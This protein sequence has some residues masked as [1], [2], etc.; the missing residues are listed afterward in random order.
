VVTSVD[1][2]TLGAVGGGENAFLVVESFPVG[3]QWIVPND[4][5]TH[6]FQYPNGIVYPAGFTFNFPNV[7]YSN[8]GSAHL[9][10]FLAS[11]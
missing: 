8:V 7:N 10:G 9:R 5:T 2:E 6:S 1:I 4:Q 11:I 3:E